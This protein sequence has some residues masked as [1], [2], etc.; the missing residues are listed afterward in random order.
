MGYKYIDEGWVSS[1]WMR[2]G[3]WYMDEEW[4]TGS[5]MKDGLQ[6]HG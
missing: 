6:V 3:L 2:K 1:V 5:W 4:V